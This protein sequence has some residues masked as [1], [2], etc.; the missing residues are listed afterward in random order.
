MKIIFHGAAKEVGKSC[1]E[2]NSKKK[3]YL[4]DAG[5]KFIQHGVEYPKYLDKI[6]D[7]DGIFI[8]HAHLDHSGALPMLEHK[9]LNCPIY[10]TKLTWKIA[11][12]LLKDSYHLEKLKHVHPAYLERDIRRVE[13]DLHYVK[14]DQTY[15]TKDNEIKFQFLN[16]GHI[17]GSASILMEMEGKTLL[18]TADINTEQTYLM[19]T[20]EI[21]NLQNNIDILIVESTYGDRRHP[22]KEETEKIFLETITKAI[23]EGG[24]VLIPVF[25]VGRSQEILIILSKLNIEVPIYFDGMAKK[26]TELTINS[27]DPYIANKDVLA[28]M[29]QSVIIPNPRQRSEISRKK[30]IIILTTSGMVQG[31]PVISY[32]EKFISDKDNYFILTGYQA[33]GTNGRSIF[34]DH[35]FYNRHQ[36]FPVRCHV[37]KFDFSAHLGQDSI[38]NLIRKIKP[39]HLILQHGDV[40]AI[41]SLAKYVNDNY[42]NEIEVHCPHV[43]WEKEF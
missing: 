10:M 5:I 42:D 27:S 22:D 23:K 2:I 20:S 13:K 1:I 29:F 6:S 35:L 26:I 14:Y 15:H 39:K 3:R 12:L 8:S 9:R 4:L 36:R 16:S 21:E 19:K 31:G 18:Y 41:E 34:E 33:N 43:G 37:R 11:N 30:G 7:L 40:N 32:A 38:H 17:P 25:S 24:S 28:K